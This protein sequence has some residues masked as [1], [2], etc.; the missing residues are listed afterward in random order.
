MQAVKRAGSVGGC[1]VFKDNSSVIAENFALRRCE[2]S[3]KNYQSSKN[4]TSSIRTWKQAA[5][6]SSAIK[7]GLTQVIYGTR[8]ITR[9]AGNT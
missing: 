3:D 2:E 9:A 1:S 6:S 8:G 5:F 4:C 7:K